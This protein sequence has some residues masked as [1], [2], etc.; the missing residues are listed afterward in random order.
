MHPCTA[1]PATSCCDGPWSRSRGAARGSSRSATG[2][3][4]PRS[5]SRSSGTASRSTS[6][7]FEVLRPP[8]AFGSGFTGLLAVEGV[9]VTMQVFAAF[10]SVPD[11]DLVP[12]ATAP[13]LRRIA[14]H[15]YLADKVQCVL[16]R[17]EARGLVDIAAVL[18]KSPPMERVLS[19]AVAAQDALLLAE[20]LL[21]W[22]LCRSPGAAPSST[23]SASEATAQHGRLAHGLLVL[24]RLR[25]CGWQG[26]V[27]EPR[28]S[29]TPSLHPRSKGG[30]S[31]RPR[32]DS[33]WG[34]RERRRAP[35]A[36]RP[37]AS[38]PEPPRRDRRRFSR[39][40]QGRP[41]TRRSPRRRA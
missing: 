22:L 19:R 29:G 23:C 38:S 4:P 32:G 1:G 12:S 16:E 37:R 17:L 30:K 6:G 8:D 34:S 28:S 3:G 11:G 26:R 27:I 31:S 2:R 10:E 24:R 36:R 25:L 14:L 33:S 21:G 18:R 39:V 13:K 9:Q 7:G 35:P 40:S 20:R 41:P 5:R 15:R